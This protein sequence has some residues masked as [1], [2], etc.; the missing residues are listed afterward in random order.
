[1]DTFMASIMGLINHMK[2]Y[3]EDISYR[4]VVEKILRSLPLK[5]N[6]LVAP[7]EETK[8]LDT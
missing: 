6:S 2:S 3:G 5:F 8:D 1:M 7:I 4:R